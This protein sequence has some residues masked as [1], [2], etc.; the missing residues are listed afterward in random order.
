M[1]SRLEEASDGTGA[2]F[3]R[4]VA[5]G[6]AQLGKFPRSGSAIG[7]RGLRRLLVAGCRWVIVY[8]LEARGILLHAL[9][10]ARQSPATTARLLR[11]ITRGLSANE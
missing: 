6:L 1:F 7:P 4:Q 5:E 2:A 11:E 9:I 3:H 10:D 8:R